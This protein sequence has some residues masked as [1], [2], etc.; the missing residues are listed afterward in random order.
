MSFRSRITLLW[1][2]DALVNLEKDAPTAATGKSNAA[3]SNKPARSKATKSGDDSFFNML[4]AE[5][6][7][8]RPTSGVS[9]R[10]GPIKKLADSVTNNDA[11]IKTPKKAEEFDDL[12]EFFKSLE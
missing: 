1:Y 10:K 8:E 2:L 5:V 11:S 6:S 7:S 3:R 9:N 12:D 4:A